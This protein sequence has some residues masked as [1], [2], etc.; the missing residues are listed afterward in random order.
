MKDKEAAVKWIA[1][2]AEYYLQG[3]TPKEAIEFAT[4][5]FVDALAS[6]MVK[7]AV[8]RAIGHVFGNESEFI[9]DKT[10]EWLAKSKEKAGSIN[11][12]TCERCGNKTYVR[13][14]NTGVTPF[15]IGCYNGDCEGPSQSGFYRL[16]SE[17]WLIVATQG[18]THVYFRPFDQAEFDRWVEWRKKQPGWN[19]EHADAIVRNTMDHVK[20][21]GLILAKKDWDK[22]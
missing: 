16:T 13:M 12:Y 6:S 7:K 14:L 9:D 22:R 1:E 20:K 2:R 8:G 18:C 15:L 3:V 5:E 4:R 10:R 11:V 17:D 21:G 19:E